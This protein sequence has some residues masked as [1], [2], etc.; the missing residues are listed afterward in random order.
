M[1]DG[2]KDDS[3]EIERRAA[4]WVARI[5][6]RPLDGKEREAFRQWLDAH[7]DH[8]PAFEEA[9]SAW[10][11]LDTLRANPAPW[12]GAPR[13]ARRKGTG[14]RNIGALVVVALLAL[15]GLRYHIGDPWIALSAD[16]RTDPGE[17]R[18]VRLSDGTMLELGP[19]S[20]VAL[21]FT[22]EER[23]VS[24]LVGEAFFHAAPRQ[25]A[26][27][28]AFIVDAAGGTTT[29][30][31]TE[32]AVEINDSGAN[33]VAVEHQVQVALDVA[34]EMAGATRSVTLSPGDA[35]RYDSRR[36]LGGVERVDVARATAWRQD[37]LVFNAAPLGEVVAR[38]NRYR[39]GRIVIWD[40]ALAQRRVTGVF[41]TRDLGDAIDT[42]TSELGIRARSVPA[43]ITVLY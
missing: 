36:G 42:I 10:R 4:E 24:L 31:G 20:A 15:A 1:D 7:P 19:A 30:L 37:M 34:L 25:G 22:A 41:P 13:P 2:V 18:Q 43:L 5:D 38:L 6:G 29:A 27:R 39:R 35:V 16:H 14:R 8:R 40:P 26:E 11:S 23:R 32:F 3:G 9:H 17:R 28:R 12:Q 21:H 33:V